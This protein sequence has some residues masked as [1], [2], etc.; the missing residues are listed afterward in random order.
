[1]N[2][3]LAAAQTDASLLIAFPAPRGL[4]MISSLHTV[5]RQTLRVRNIRRMDVPM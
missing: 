2:Q 5:H 4:Q 1:M 3:P